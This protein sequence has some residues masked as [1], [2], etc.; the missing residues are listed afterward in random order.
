MSTTISQLMMDLPD[1][2]DQICYV[3]CGFCTTIL[4]VSVPSTSMSMAAVTVRCGHCTSLL[5]VNMTKASFLPFHLL[6]AGVDNDENR[7]CEEGGGG[8]GRDH[9]K[10][11]SFLFMDGGSS[12]PGLVTCDENEEE[13]LING[14]GGADL[15]R[16]INKPPEKRQRAPSAYN[17]FIKEEIK[18]LKAEN[19]SMVHKEAFSMAAKNV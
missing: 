13:D 17:R 10:A 19:P 12:P 8:R 3:Q 5:S 2:E 16:K 1:H 7:V 6:A 14:S 11:G 15:G 4:L 9:E 18:R